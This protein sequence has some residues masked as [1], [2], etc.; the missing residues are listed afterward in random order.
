MEAVAIT[1]LPAVGMGAAVGGGIGII[2]S[3]VANVP[4]LQILFLL[5]GMAIGGYIGFAGI[6][7][8]SFG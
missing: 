2:L 6:D 1:D 8:P 7:L 3:S 5:L 4:S